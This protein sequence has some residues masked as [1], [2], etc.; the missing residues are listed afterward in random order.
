MYSLIEV[1]IDDLVV[2]RHTVDLVVDSTFGLSI[3]LSIRLD[4]QVLATAILH[5]VS[6][7]SFE[8]NLE[9]G[10]G[11]CLLA[12]GDQFAALSNELSIEGA[13][14]LESAVG[15]VDDPALVLA[16]VLGC[17]LGCSESVG[18]LALG[19]GRV[20]QGVA[21]VFKGEITP[22]GQGTDHLLVAIFEVQGILKGLLAVW[23][24]RSVRGVGRFTEAGTIIVA[25][26]VSERGLGSRDLWNA[27][28][29][30]ESS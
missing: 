6:L 20:G 11:F 26:R 14:N 23:H 2:V 8:N 12:G 1:I 21:V 17:C 27:V 7:S 29:G 3:D 4:G 5:T 10:R 28:I 16:V 18:A 19:G 13:R 30:L 24:W 15:T 22:F 9:F 25:V